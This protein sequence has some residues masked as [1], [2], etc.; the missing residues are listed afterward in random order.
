MAY[1][2]EPARL[3]EPGQTPARGHAEQLLCGSQATV[4]RDDFVDEHA[5]MLSGAG[6]DRKSVLWIARRADAQAPKTMV[7]GGLCVCSRYLA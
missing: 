1:A 5:L 4:Y 6:V 3:D 7:F 2:N